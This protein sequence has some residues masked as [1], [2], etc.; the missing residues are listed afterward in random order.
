MKFIVCFIFISA[1]IF[2][3]SSSLPSNEQLIYNNQAK[4][5]L[6][7]RFENGYIAGTGFSDDIT[8][9][10]NDAIVFSQN[11]GKF[12]PVLGEIPDVPSGGQTL[13]TSALYAYA[14]DDID[15]ANTVIDEIL[16]IVNTNNL[17]TTFWNESNT[18]RWDSENALWI[19]TAKVK[20]LKDSYYF[21]K[22]LQTS[23]GENDKII[24][25]N[26]FTRY[27]ELAE[28]AVRARL[29]NLLGST[30]EA[31]GPTTINNALYPT[32]GG[33]ATPTPVYNQN[34][35]I[36]DDYTIVLGQ[37][38]FNNR[39]WD[40]ISY[41]HSWAVFNN[42]I[43]SETWTREFFKNA[44]KYGLF[45]DGSWCELFRN[46]DSDPTLGVFYGYITLGGM[47]AMA[48]LDAIANNFPLDKLYDYET[49][50]GLVNGSTTLT[51]SGYLGGSTTDGI[52]KKSL[53]TFLKGQSN[54]LRSSVDGGWNDIRFFK[55]TDN[56]ITPLSTVGL[57]QPSVIPAM[58]NIYYKNQELLDWYNYETTRGYPSKV[59]I[60]E[61]YLAGGVGNEDMGP[62][63][64]MI[65]GLAWYNQED[66]FDSASLSTSNNNPLSYL[67]IY[68]NPAK[69]EI[70]IS[71]HSLLKDK[72]LKLSIFDMSLR[73]VLI[74]NKNV[75]RIDISPLPPGIYFIKLNNGLEI[76][77]GKFIKN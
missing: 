20:K 67:T 50:E 16:S 37:D 57:R 2:A 54:Y 42:D 30:W 26:W 28:E 31:T 68:P 21:I 7:Q 19:Q 40:A 6:K 72:N 17:Y 51:S 38:T 11:P 24:I 64:N 18:L 69:Q 66:S 3:Q 44:I 60:S 13:H 43:D 55:S 29:S 15:L 23:L 27:K 35:D 71:N 74:Q 9:T 8:K 76:N 46:R 12:R 49:T 36:I 70:F 4:E 75:N 22:T 32:F 63:G 62:W 61:G 39:Q 41:I 10:L 65:L 48:H 45:P 47:V 59:T 5:I 52:T 58:A 56:I 1:Q 34:G 77:N 73:E 25:E 33:N 53:Y 14:I